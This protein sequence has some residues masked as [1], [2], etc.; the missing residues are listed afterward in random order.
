LFAARRPTYVI[1]RI[2]KEP[3]VYSHQR[4]GSE[5]AWSCTFIHCID[6]LLFSHFDSFNSLLFT[7]YIHMILVIY[8]YTLWWFCI[9]REYCGKCLSIKQSL[10]KF[11]GFEIKFIDFKTKEKKL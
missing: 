4:D 7:Y 9:R 8:V 5:S 10:R 2:N 3:G 11:F 1:R 6:S